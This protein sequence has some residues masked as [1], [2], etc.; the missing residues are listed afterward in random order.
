MYLYKVTN[1][2]A[3]VAAWSVSLVVHNLHLMLP[4]MNNMCENMDVC[5]CVSEC[6]RACV[7]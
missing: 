3:C 6:V 5:M 2:T 7:C 1:K 4:R